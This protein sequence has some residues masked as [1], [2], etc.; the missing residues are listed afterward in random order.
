MAL[1]QR[2]RCRLLQLLGDMTSAEFSRRMDVSRSIVSRWIS[3]ERE[4]SFENIV[5]ASR[6]LNCHAED[7]YEMIEKPR[8][9]KR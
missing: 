8:K 7:L 2:G 5:M 3:G 4:M 1:L 6:I 9:S